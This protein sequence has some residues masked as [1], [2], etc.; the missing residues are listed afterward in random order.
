MQKA[1]P[2]KI[3]SWSAIAA[4]IAGAAFV[5]K[6][7]Y[8]FVID[9]SE[10]PVVAIPYLLGV[11]LPLFAAAGV[12][13]RAATKLPARI[14]V[15]LLVAIAHLMFVMT[16]SEAFEVAITSATSLS[17]RHATE[18][19]ILLAG[20]VWLVVGYRLWAGPSRRRM[21]IGDG[22]VTST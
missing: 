3:V 4:M 7:A 6:V 1:E 13:A 17:E 9:F 21:P 20:L 5:F 18:I 11:L 10:S 16:F 14:G 19:P 2:S 8:L 22:A 12:A 15:Y